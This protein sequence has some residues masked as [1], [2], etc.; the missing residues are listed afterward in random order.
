MLFQKK[1]VDE[2]S[3]WQNVPS[4]AS[5]PSSNLIG[6][7]AAFLLQRAMQVAS[8]LLGHNLALPQVFRANSSWTEVKAEHLWRAEGCQ[9][10]QQERFLPQGSRAA[11]RGAGFVWPHR[12][13]R[14]VEGFLTVKKRIVHRLLRDG[15]ADWRRVVAQRIFVHVFVLGSFFPYVPM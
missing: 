2:N 8:R 15:L 5:F 14:K 6:L 11:H 1:T 9:V 3:S 12:C 10:S 4:Y 13:Q 7:E